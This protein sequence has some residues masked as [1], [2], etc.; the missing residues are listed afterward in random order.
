MDFDASKKSVLS[1]M[2]KSKIGGID[3]GIKKLVELINS[4]PDYYTTSSCS[5]RILLI[6]KPD[7]GRKNEVKWIFASHDRV[8]FSDIRAALKQIS[9]KKIWFRQESMIIHIC[10]RS[11]DSAVKMLNLCQSSG[12]KRAGIIAAGRKII[13]EAFGTERMD[14][15]VTENGNMLVSDDYLKV[16]VREANKKMEHNSGRIKRLYEKIKISF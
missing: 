11:L 2:D 12:L 9:K 3:R 6:E 16:L 5:G 13:V 7:S 15:I 10:C 4:L 14:T 1:R 8:K